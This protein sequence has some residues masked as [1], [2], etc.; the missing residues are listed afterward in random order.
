M[1]LGGISPYYANSTFTNIGLG[2]GKA[3][4]WNVPL[5]SAFFGAFNVNTQGNTFA[6]INTASNLILLS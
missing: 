4:A 1:N 5:E 3:V 6:Y 2:G